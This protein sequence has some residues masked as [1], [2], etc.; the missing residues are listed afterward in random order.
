M[1][2]R[3][4]AVLVLAAVVIGLMAPSAFAVD[5]GCQ[6]GEVTVGFYGNSYAEKVMVAGD[7]TILVPVTWLTTYGLMEFTEESGHYVF[8]PAGQKHDKIFAKRIRIDKSGEA[9][10]YRCNISRVDSVLIESYSFSE[11][12]TEG[13]ILYLP[14]TEFLPLFNARME[15]KDGVLHITPNVMSVFE[16]LYGLDLKAL[17]FD[18][19]RD[20][21]GIT[22]ESVYYSSY[23][24]D[25]IFGFR[26]DR[27]DI[28]YHT[29][30]IKDLNKLFK[31]Y[32][33]DD[34]V[35]LSAYDN[36][37]TPEEKAWKTTTDILKGIDDQ[38]GEAK[39]F[40]SMVEYML[41][42]AQ[43][44][45]M[46]D[47]TEGISGS[48]DI[49]GEAGD[50]AEGLYKAASY[51]RAYRNHVEDHRLMLNAVYGGTYYEAGKAECQAAIEMTALYGSEYADRLVSLTVSTLRELVTGTMVGEAVK[52]SELLMPY[53]IAF[54]VVKAV[55]PDA[56]EEIGDGA[57][58]YHMHDVVKDSCD[59]FED[60]IRHLTFDEKSLNEL[61]LTA[62]MALV[63]SRVAYETYW[64][65]DDRRIPPI[66]EILTKLYLAADSVYYE[67]AESYTDQKRELSDTVMNLRVTTYGQ[68]EEI[69]PETEAP[70]ADNSEALR[71]YAG[72]LAG[73]YLSDGN[74]GLVSATHYSLFDMNGDGISE[75]IVLTM[76]DTRP[77]FEIYTYRNGQ[78]ERIADSLNTCDVTEWYNAA[79]YVYICDG[80]HVFAGAEKATGAYEAHSYA[81]LKYDGQNVSTEDRSMYDV[82]TGYGVYKLVENGEIVGGIR[83]GSEEDTLSEKQPEETEPQE[84]E[85]QETE[86]PATEPSETEPVFTRSGYSVEDFLQHGF[87]VLLN[88]CDDYSYPYPE[89]DDYV[90]AHLDG[91]ELAVDFD[92]ETGD[93]EKITVWLTGGSLEITDGVYSDMSYE[94]MKNAWANTSGWTDIQYDFPYGGSNPEMDIHDAYVEFIWGEGEISRSEWGE[95]S[96]DR[97]SVGANQEEEVRT[98]WGYYYY[99]CARCGAHMHGY[100]DI[101]YTWAGGC[102]KAKIPHDWHE[103]WSTVS[104]NEA[105]LRDWHGTGKLYTYLDGELVFKWT[106]HGSARQQYRYRTTGSGDGSDVRYLVTLRFVTPMS[107]TDGVPVVNG[108][109]I[110]RID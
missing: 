18:M 60:R 1:K 27:L 4:I 63:A 32:L 48:N 67:S 20:M 39:A 76:V 69:P 5:S 2:K 94:G 98:V 3:I 92:L 78:V 19:E 28:M 86:P 45:E 99:P 13:G 74:G 15:I 54:G 100:N 105:N 24:L 23:I 75:I 79:N 64:Y 37:L 38:L 46:D 41:D 52:K 53:K 44:S 31:K 77:T 6:A 55:I 9:A 66:N 109:T 110:E 29:G 91:E 51:E 40:P 71:A 25:S 50:I 12:C 43:F 14:L 82:L 104:W 103:V 73:V 62:I 34:A 106:E 42:S 108:I 61:R 30:E 93:I 87:G 90:V 83:I 33:I 11:S 26:F 56:M 70:A 21:L 49:L 72:I 96:F 107:L 97:Q 10:E 59:V 8:Y 81:M 35:Y 80:R 89:Y 68:Q 65:E 101:C 58:L 16:A 36:E 85:P 102:G 47:L 88:V 95:W 22:D 57:M 7:G 17:S 84:T